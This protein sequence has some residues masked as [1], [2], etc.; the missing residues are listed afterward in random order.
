MRRG[1]PMKKNTPLR[2]S[3]RMFD[4]L[5]VPNVTRQAAYTFAV[6]R[7]PEPRHPIKQHAKGVK[8]RTNPTRPLWE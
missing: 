5:H 4:V 8:P 1:P 2:L 7:P 3:I 6:A